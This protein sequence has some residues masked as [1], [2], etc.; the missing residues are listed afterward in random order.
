MTNIL[1][2]VVEDGPAL[3]AEHG[4]GSPIGGAARSGEI[5]EVVVFL[6]SA[7]ASFIV[8]AVVMAAGGMSVTAG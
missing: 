5:A 8:G 3:L 4:K 7:R 6:A 1:N 2:H